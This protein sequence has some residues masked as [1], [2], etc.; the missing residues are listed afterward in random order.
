MGLVPKW[1]IKVNNEQ[2]C[3]EKKQFQQASPEISILPLNARVGL[4]SCH[5]AIILSST[6]PGRRHL[7]E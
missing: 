5:S 7:G 4:H 2:F 6:I 1:N 3:I